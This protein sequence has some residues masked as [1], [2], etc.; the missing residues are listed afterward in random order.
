M[1]QVFF[2]PAYASEG[3]YSIG[4]KVARLCACL[5]LESNWPARGLVALKVQIG[6]RGR[7]LPWPAAWGLPL[8]K[9]MHDRGL[10][11][12]YT[13]T[14]ALHRGDL[15]NAV[16][17]Q[18]AA[19]ER[20]F[21]PATAGAVYL[22][23]DGLAGESE[24]RQPIA[25]GE[26]DTVAMAA[27]PAAADGLVVLNHCTGHALAGFHGVIMSLGYGLA[28]R[29]GKLW[30]C[31]VLKP[32]VDVPMCAG[33]GVCAE[34]CNYDAIRF[35][36][37]RAFIDHE[38]C[39]GCGQCMTDCYLEGIQPEREKGCPVFQ[40]RIAEY[41]L[42]IAQ[43]KQGRAIYLNCL[44][45]VTPNADSVGK[46]EQSLFGDIGLLVS[47]DPVAVDQA[48]LDRVG[49]VTGRPLSAW[50]GGQPDPEPLL[51]HAEFLGLGS[52]DYE[53]TELKDD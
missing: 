16:V 7:P 12:F 45:K 26:C 8:A 33:C 23:A 47:S 49:S 25:G 4:E 27:L 18:K 5:K 21:T 42:G 11:P 20:G 38:T 43:G 28:S 35:D 2:L 31:E 3:P 46:R 41:A 30:M 19:V 34:V 9:R 14:C 50:C 36:G 13:D 1:S 22:V 39:I 24:I 32:Q 17:H 29:A 52:R 51:A 53:L 44:I 6:E 10:F 15:N 48:A 40:R 37:G